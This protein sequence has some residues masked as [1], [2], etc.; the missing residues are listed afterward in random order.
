MIRDIINKIKWAYQRVV[1]GYDDT[2][3]WEFDSYFSRFIRPLEE[4]C[5]SELKYDN[6][7][8]NKKRARVFTT[9]LKLI[10]DYRKMKF[11]DFYKKDNAQ[12]RL[13][14]YFGKHIDY[15]WN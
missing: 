6:I 8:Y 3:K 2:I 1:R 14:E 12:S 4:F 7:Q 11:E 5:K 15:Y 13:W 9:T 10:K